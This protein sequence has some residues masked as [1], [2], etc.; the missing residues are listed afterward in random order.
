MRIS[1]SSVLANVVISES[2][3]LAAVSRGEETVSDSTS[4]EIVSGKAEGRDQAGWPTLT[5][6][7]VIVPA[8]DNA[9]LN[10]YRRIHC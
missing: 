10:C 1:G 7:M 8:S 4:W 5:V 3:V 2:V 6:R 9:F